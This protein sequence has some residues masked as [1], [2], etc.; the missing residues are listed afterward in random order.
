MKEYFVKYLPYITT[1]LVIYFSPIIGDLIFVGGLVMFDWITGILK[2]IKNSDF[3]S[4]IA[5]R[6]LWVSIGYL[7]GLMVVRSIELH[8]NL[9]NETI[10]KPVV[11]IITVA[12]LQS[13]RE[14]FKELTGIDILKPV[15]NLFK[16]K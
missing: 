6:K 14:N 3:K 7:M 4:E 1:S 10:V 12:E 11:A 9:E 5:I 13:L 8:Y 2:G 15:I 16:K